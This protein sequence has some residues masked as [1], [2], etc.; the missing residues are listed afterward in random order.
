MGGKMCFIIWNDRIT[1][2][3][4]SRAHLEEGLFVADSA[5]TKL[6]YSNMNNSN[7]SLT[8][9]LERKCP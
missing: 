6:R 8:D 3:W 1:L 5:N 4:F 7:Y 9:Y 2:E